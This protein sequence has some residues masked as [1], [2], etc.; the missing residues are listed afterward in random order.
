MRNDPAAEPAR[1]PEPS[2]VARTRRC[3]KCAE[4]FDSE[5][6]GERICRRCK[7]TAVWREGAA[8]GTFSSRSRP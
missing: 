3:L 7:G 8:L 4:A 5:W 1:E 6:A 2:Q